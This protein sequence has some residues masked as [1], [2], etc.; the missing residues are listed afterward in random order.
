M[1]QMP[2]TTLIFTAFFVLM[3]VPISILVG[4]R[5][6]ETGIMML[7]G[8][9]EDLLRRIRAHGNFIEYVPLALLAMAGAEIA[10]APSWLVLAC[11]VA[12]L[13]ARLIHYVALRR[14]PTGSGRLIGAALTSLT[15]LVLAASILLTLGGVI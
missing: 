8:D 10:G 12:L 7:H 1:D 5:R 15:M 14:N 3:S 4:L 9:D 11:G 6:A 2:Q 13:A